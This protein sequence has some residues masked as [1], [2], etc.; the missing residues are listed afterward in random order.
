MSQ[1]FIQSMGL[2][3]LG[4]TDVCDCAFADAAGSKGPNATR[5]SMVQWSAAMNA[6]VVGTYD[7]SIRISRYDLDDV[8]SGRRECAPPLTSGLAPVLYMANVL[9]AGT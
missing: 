8:G 3:P 9:P 1:L 5:V 2:I 4:D 6:V 7:G